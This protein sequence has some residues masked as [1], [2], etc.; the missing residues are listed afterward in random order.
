VVILITLATKGWFAALILLAIFIGENQIESHLLQPLV[1]GRFVRLHP[2][3]IILALGV[4]GV[5][6]GI[7]GAVVAVPIAAAIARAAPELRRPG[8]PAGP[9]AGGCGGDS[10]SAPG[11]R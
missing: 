4:G 11:P 7:P 6:A 1:V 2:L 5:V 9:G 10:D 8:P 3:G